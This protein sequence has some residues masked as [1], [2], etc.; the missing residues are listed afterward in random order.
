MAPVL[1]ATY[2][3]GFR[4]VQSK[5]TGQLSG[6][7]YAANFL[8]CIARIFTSL[9]EGGGYAMVRGYLLGGVSA[10]RIL[11]FIASTAGIDMLFDIPY[12]INTDPVLHFVLQECCSMA[13]SF[14]RQSSTRN[15]Q[16]KRWLDV[17]QGLL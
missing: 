14:Y 10:M 9:Q 2:P 3:F 6:T 12:L 11:L 16:R 13:P 8:G 17:R 15:C 5:S 1:E 4:G 7:M